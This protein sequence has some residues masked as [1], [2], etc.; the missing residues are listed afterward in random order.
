MARATR[1][2]VS[3]MGAALVG[4]VVQACAVSGL[5]FEQDDRI[6][7]QS[8]P[9]NETVRL[10]FEVRW[11]AR[12]FDGRYVVFFDRSPMRPN[13]TLRSLVPSN[14]PC[15]ARTGC[16]DAAWLAERDI[17]VTSGTTVRIEAL[18]EE[19]AN[20][21]SKDRH[22]LTVVL[23]DERGRR[24]GESAFVREFIVERDD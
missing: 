19:R 17:Y 6:N 10:P 20:N 3:W 14:D 15:R 2:R 13:Q 23:L 21:R 11:T 12:D 24:A 22:R 9:A 18:P 7:L 4:L 5:S 1:R 16:P 8:P